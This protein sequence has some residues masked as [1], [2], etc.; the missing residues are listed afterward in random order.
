MAPRYET[1]KRH[2]TDGIAGGRYPAG[3]RLP[4]E[5]ELVA[6]L[7]VSRMTVNRALRE[8]ARDGIIARRQGI[9]SFVRDAAPLPSLAD[10]R[11]VREIIAERGGRHSCRVDAAE[12][13][14]AGDTIGALLGVA[15]D[16]PVFHVH[17]IHCED[18]VP[19][20]SERRYVL[21]RFAPGLLG[22]DFTAL[23]L[24]PWL[25]RFG[26]VSELE[27][28]VEAGLA[29]PGEQADLALAPGDPVLRIRRRTWL[30]DQGVTV[31]HFVQPG[32][33]YRVQVRLRPGDYPARPGQAPA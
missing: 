10:V 1:V 31:G 17:L 18:G 12:E 27:H 24:A 16:T 22:V 30:G 29:D 9:G 6:A 25:Q 3:G 21:A 15:A 33:R 19:L 20:Q 8:L 26:P 32:A 14:P 2:I 13:I 5:M 4:S 11:D 7:G 23:P 28:V